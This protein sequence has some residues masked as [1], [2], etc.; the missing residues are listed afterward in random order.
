MKKLGE[1]SSISLA[2]F[3]LNLIKKRLEKEENAVNATKQLNINPT[4]N[5]KKVRQPMECDL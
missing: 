5:K 2:N 3:Y 1:T 4:K